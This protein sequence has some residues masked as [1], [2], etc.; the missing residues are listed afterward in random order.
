MSWDDLTGDVRVDA[1]AMWAVEGV[2]GCVWC[3]RVQQE[4]RWVGSTV[5]GPGTTPQS[6][7][8]RGEIRQDT[9]PQQGWKGKNVWRTRHSSRHD[10]GIER[11]Y[12]A[13][14]RALAWV[15]AHSV[16]NMSRIM[17]S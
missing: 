3:L 11:R 15:N 7:L 8:S 16:R 2:L 6:Y 4:K 1:R 12:K 13:L 9:S 14:G 5:G 17:A 10:S